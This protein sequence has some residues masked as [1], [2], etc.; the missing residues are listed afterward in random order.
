MGVG[1]KIG[2]EGLVA[3]EAERLAEVI[4]AAEDGLMS[5]RA[6]DRLLKARPLCSKASC[7]SIKKCLQRGSGVERKWFP[8]CPSG[9]M[10]LESGEEKMQDGKM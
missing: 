3:A 7:Q 10:P 6:I 5:A 2:Q 8:M 9:R 4:A 1:G